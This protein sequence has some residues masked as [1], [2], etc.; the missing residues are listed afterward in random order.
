MSKGNE[1]DKSLSVKEIMN[2]VM[3]LE[4]SF[5]ELESFFTGSELVRGR[6][7]TWLSHYI[8]SDLSVPIANKKMKLS[9]HTHYHWTRS[10][11]NYREIF[12]M[13]AQSR[14]RQAIENIIE[15]SDLNVAKC[16][17]T[18]STVLKMTDNEILSDYGLTNV[19]Q[20]VAGVGGGGGGATNIQINIDL[21][22]G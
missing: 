5:K 13:L 8:D 16:Q 19:N 3:D 1:I 18:A 4:L 9:R 6:K 14:T 22:D 15:Q 10:D 17:L 12:A 20:K 2:N 7:S 21:S 11:N